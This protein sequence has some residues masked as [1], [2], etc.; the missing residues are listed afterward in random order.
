MDA[1]K[2]TGTRIVIGSNVVDKENPLNIPVSSTEG[3]GN[4]IERVIQTYNNSLNG[5]VTAWAMPFSP[6]YC[7][8]NLLKAAKE[9]ADKYDT[10]LTLHYNN[11]EGFINKTITSTGKRPTEVLAELG[12]LDSN[13]LLAHG[14]GIHESEL[15]LLRDSDTKIAICPTAA[16][17]SGSGMSHSSLVP[18][19][20]DMLSLIHISEPTRPY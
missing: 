13:T 5:T 7:S 2:L 10:G 14:L 15:Q 1:Y 4:E 12:I 16:I 18:E 8:D 9:I 20:L 3:A 19:M 11:S 17:K 6:A